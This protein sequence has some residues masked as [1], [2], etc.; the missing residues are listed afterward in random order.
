MLSFERMTES[1]VQ[2]AQQ[3]TY[4]IVEEV[5]ENPQRFVLSPL[6]MVFWGTRDPQRFASEF[7]DH[8]M[9]MRIE[10]VRGKAL[11]SF[12][13]QVVNE[14]YSVEEWLDLKL[15]HVTR[16]DLLFVSAGIVYAVEV[17]FAANTMNGDTFNGKRA[18]L[19]AYKNY[20]EAQGKT[21]RSMILFLKEKSFQEQM[22]KDILTL[23]GPAAWRWVFRNEEHLQDMILSM[24]RIYNA[25]R[26]TIRNEKDRVVEKAQT[27]LRLYLDKNG[28]IDPLRLPLEGRNCLLSPRLYLQKG[29]SFR[30]PVLYEPNGKEQKTVGHVSSEGVTCTDGSRWD[31]SCVEDVVHDTDPFP[32]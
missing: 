20:F 2:G 26:D 16:P 32:R 14:T 11:E 22:K 23:W 24:S 8:F 19:L 18:S 28:R 1:V 27:V 25:S 12:V 7:Y 6:E 5:L 21:V 17:K 30:V 15:P 29:D 4:E 9:S 13:R 10:D 31:W 3:K